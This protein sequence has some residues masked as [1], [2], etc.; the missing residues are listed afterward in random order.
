M[1]FLSR[2]LLIIAAAFCLLAGAGAWYWLASSDDPL[3]NLDV[4]IGKQ[5]LV[6]PAGYVHD[7]AQRR[8]G[9]FSELELAADA[10]TFRPAPR[11][12]KLTLETEDALQRIVFISM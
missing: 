3:R 4:R 8:S 1:A 12:V 11:A 5:R 7:R 10:R 2:P 9:E 6:I